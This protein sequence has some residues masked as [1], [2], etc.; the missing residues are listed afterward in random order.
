MGSP[1]IYSP[2]FGDM[3]NWVVGGGAAAAGGKGEPPPLPAAVKYK[4][5][6]SGCEF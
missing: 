1:L 3:N 6:I 4:E 5:N 2:A